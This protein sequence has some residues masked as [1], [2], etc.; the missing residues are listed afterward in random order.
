ME[1]ALAASIAYRDQIIAAHPPWAM[2]TYCAILKETNR[3]G[4]SGLSRVDRL[5]KS[6]GRFPRRLYWEA[7]WTI[8]GWAEHRKFSIL[9]VWEEEA[10]EMALAAR[11][12]GLE[13]VAADTFSPFATRSTMRTRLA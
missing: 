8:G 5:E 3:S 10:F 11:Q 12:T 9:K 13:A 1:Q 4:V 6:K 7:Q 2:P